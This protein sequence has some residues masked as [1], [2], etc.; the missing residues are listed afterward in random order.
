MT[1]VPLEL[2]DHLDHRVRLVHKGH[3]DLQDREAKLEMLVIKE[4]KD[5]AKD[6]GRASILGCA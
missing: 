4:I 2:Q 1:Q 6:R 3:R 5:L